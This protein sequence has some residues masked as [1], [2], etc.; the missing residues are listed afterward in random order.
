MIEVQ[1]NNTQTLLIAVIVLLIGRFLQ[2]KIKILKKFFI[3]PPVIGGFLF[4]VF[5]TIDYYA[6]WIHVKINPDLSSMF[7]VIFFSTVGFSATLKFLKKGGKIVFVFLVCAVIFVILQNVVGIAIALVMGKSAAFGMAT[8]SIPMTGGHGTAAAFGPILE[9]RFGVDNAATISIAAATVGLFAG[10]LIGGPVGRRLLNKY[11]LK[12]NPENESIQDETFTPDEDKELKI[13]EHGMFHAV[14][15]VA[16]AVGLGAIVSY[17][18]NK[19]EL[20]VPSYIGAMLVA[21]I[22]RNFADGTGW[23]KIFDNELKVVGNI[24]LSLFLVMALM[25]MELWVLADLAFPI[26]ILL[27]AQIA[28]MAFYAYF[29]TFRMLGKD[30]D[31]AVMA[32]GH[33]GFGLGATPNAI[34]NMEAFTAQNYPSPQAFFVLPLVGALFIDFI[35]SGLVSTLLNIIG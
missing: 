29:V 13:T 17:Y 27:L 20:I 8:A 3:P 1:L 12:P 25:Q 30:Y 10:S 6:D 31:A 23:F 11:S 28:L 18:I 16:I 33:C 9:S 7:M 5:L 4:S 24:S 26:I 32:C 21:A 22:I 35:N 34:A 15:I 2:N 14:A 19:L